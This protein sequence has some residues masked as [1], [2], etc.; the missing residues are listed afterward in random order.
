MFIYFLKKYKLRKAIMV[1]YS[2]FIQ[3]L[4]KKTLN[5][6]SFI[7]VDKKLIDV[8]KLPL[9]SQKK[10]IEKNEISIKEII[11]T[12]VVGLNNFEKYIKEIRNFIEKLDKK[13]ANYH[14]D[15]LSDFFETSEDKFQSNHL[16]IKSKYYSLISVECKKYNSFLLL[17]FRLRPNVKFKNTI[18]ETLKKDDD[19]TPILFNFIDSGVSIGEINYTKESYFCLIE[20]SRMSII[21][22]LKKYFPSINSNSLSTINFIYQYKNNLLKKDVESSF[23]I[24]STFYKEM[25]FKSKNICIYGEN[26]LIPFECFS[27]E[28]SSSMYSLFANGMYKVDDINETLIFLTSS[29]NLYLKNKKLLQ[30]INNMIFSE[31]NKYTKLLLKYKFM[32]EQFLVLEQLEQFLYDKN[33]TEFMKNIINLKLKDF[34]FSNITENINDLK[35][36]KKFVEEKLKLNLDL[37]KAISENKM[38]KILFVIAIFSF[39]A[40]IPD[41]KRISSSLCN[42]SIILFKSLSEILCK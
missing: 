3:S 42:Y 21:E 41:L 12:E 35:L 25:D 28:D 26:L 17:S 11:F 19:F 10:C 6:L 23:Y 16:K 5:K 20:K 34:V 30:E 18:F 4:P 38:N 2:K 40:I 33:E 32:S 37:V 31:K 36:E 1:F 27:K 22:I 24:N 9:N 7:F 13:N 14:A 15:R 39:I 29:Y 8:I